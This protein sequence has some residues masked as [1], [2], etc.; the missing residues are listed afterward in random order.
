MNNVKISTNFLLRE[1]ECRDGE[2][3]VRLDSR[4]L[5]KLQ[6]LRDKVGRPVI[7]LSGYR[8]SSYNKRVGGSPG[9]QHLLGKAADIVVQGCSVEEL[10]RIS[11][12]IGFTGIGLYDSFVHVDV[13]AKEATW[14]KKR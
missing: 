3:Q 12:E 2:H 5:Q 13:R 14:Q 11:R 4:L 10:A 6:A 9:S 7:I 1:F 8:N